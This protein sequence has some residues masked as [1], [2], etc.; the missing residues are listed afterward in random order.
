MTRGESY[1]ANLKFMGPE[2]EFS[3][4]LTDSQYGSTLTW[5]NTMCD[6]SDAREYLKVYLSEFELSEEF[7]ILKRMP[8]TWLPLTACWIARLLSR[9]CELPGEPEA[10]IIKKIYDVAQSRAIKPQATEDRQTKARDKTQTNRI[11]DVLGDIEREIDLNE[12]FSLYEYLAAKSVPRPYIQAIVTF[13]GEWFEELVEALDTDDVDLRYAYRNMSSDQLN[14]RI[15]FFAELISDAERYDSNAKNV[16]KKPIIIRTHRAVSSDKTVKN[17]K[18]MR[19]CPSLKVVSI[20][21]KKIVGASEVWC[22]N[23]RY[24]LL[25]VHRAKNGSTLSVS[26]TTIVGSDASSSITKKTGRKTA[27][28]VSEVLS[29]GKIALGKLMGQVEGSPV[30]LQSRM[31]ESI[32]ILRAL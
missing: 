11:S 29:A 14:E 28:I 4:P 32:V 22:I 12:N 21:P 17:L 30:N 1:Y 10:F 15:N 18:F 26:G 13:Y 27:E 8:D 16:V 20:D 23:T 6:A 24:N 7:E 9:G 31:T 5:Y 2:P 3:D 25:T 19:D